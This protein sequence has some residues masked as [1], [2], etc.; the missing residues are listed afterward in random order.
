MD[1][2]NKNGVVLSWNSTMVRPGVNGILPV[3]PENGEW[4]PTQKLVRFVVILYEH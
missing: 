4:E 1:L 2:K 3:P